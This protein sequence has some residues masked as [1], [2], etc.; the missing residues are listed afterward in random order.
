M[1]D[2]L[3]FKTM[4]TPAIL[5]VGSVIFIIVGVVSGFFGFF[6]IEESERTLEW[7]L[8]TIGLQSVA[9]PLGVRIVCEHLIVLFKIHETLNEIAEK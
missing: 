8:L 6:S 7:F 4:I 9:Y 5:K 2:F 3:N 1:L